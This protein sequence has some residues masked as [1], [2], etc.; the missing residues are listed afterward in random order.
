MP[1]SL[2][3][4][5]LRGK[6]GG[7][8]V[9][10]ADE[11]RPQW[12]LDAEATECGIC[13][14][15]FTSFTRRHH[16][17]NCGDVFCY[18]CTNFTHRLPEFGY[19]EEVRVCK[20]CKETLLSMGVEEMQQ[21][22]SIRIRD[23]PPI[24]A[25]Y[26]L[27]HFNHP[28]LRYIRVIDKSVSRGP[29]R[30]RKRRVLCIVDRYLFVCSTVGMVKRVVGIDRLEKI[31]VQNV[32]SPPGFWRPEATRKTLVLLTVQGEPDIFV[33]LGN[34]SRSDDSDDVLVHVAQKIH[35]AVTG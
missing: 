13:K 15:A 29:M 24:Q 35:E 20:H 7:P 12:V 11:S 17:R 19:H 23:I 30:R 31:Y 2:S 28:S 1:G 4:S 21:P 32:V 8:G 27:Q 33:M 10:E 3:L 22:D 26:Q 25:P 34:D 18:A 6:K 9:G 5:F 16:C 14:V